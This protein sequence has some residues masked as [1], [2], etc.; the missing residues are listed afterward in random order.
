MTEN[1]TFKTSDYALYGLIK[2]L[3]CLNLKRIAAKEHF[4]TGQFHV[5]I[6]Y[7]LKYEMLQL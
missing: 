2:I 5:I 3:T 6:N 1:I 4:I 7:L